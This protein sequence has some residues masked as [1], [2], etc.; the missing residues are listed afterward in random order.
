V[1][2]IEMLPAREGDCLLLSWGAGASP[3][4]ILID[5]GRAQTYSSL[6]RRLSNLP[7]T[8]REFELLVITHIDRDHIEGALRCSRIL[9]GQS[10]S[11]IYGSMDITIFGVKQSRH[12]EQFK[13][14][15]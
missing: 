2:E 5:G 13:V 10:S 3:Y 8:K 4:R 7:S 9:L 15:G 12:S 11:A 14:S 6:K 1:L